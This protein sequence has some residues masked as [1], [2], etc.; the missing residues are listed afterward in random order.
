MTH[1]IAG[2]RTE[3]DEELVVILKHKEWTHMHLKLLLQGTNLVQGL[4]MFVNKL[5]DWELFSSAWDRAVAHA[6]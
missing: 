3:V 2:L 5:T 6:V 1:A 4:P